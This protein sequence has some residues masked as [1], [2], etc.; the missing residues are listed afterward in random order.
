M[1]EKLYCE[2]C[3]IDYDIF[4]ATV[5]DEGENEGLWICPKCESV[6]EKPVK[7]QEAKQ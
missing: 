6:I 2:K 3:K 1:K 5:A 7:K 4:S